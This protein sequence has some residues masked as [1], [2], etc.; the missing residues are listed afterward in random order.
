MRRY[1]YEEYNDLGGAAGCPM[2]A[3]LSV[4]FMI[5]LLMITWGLLSGL[6]L[7]Y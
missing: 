7:M 2:I 1:N 4:I 5:A 3:V 6:W